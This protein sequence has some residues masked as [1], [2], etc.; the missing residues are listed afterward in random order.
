MTA[1]DDL[2]IYLRI[3]TRDVR[4]FVAQRPEN[5]R[6]ASSDEYKDGQGNRTLRWALDAENVAQARRP[7]M[8][9]AFGHQT[10]PTSQ[11]LTR[12]LVLRLE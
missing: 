12:Q 6:R 5:A 7:Q 11:L 9:T 8:P 2:C 3:Y 1:V 10:V 4:Q